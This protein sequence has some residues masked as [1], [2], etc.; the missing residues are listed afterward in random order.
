MSFNFFDIFG[1]HNGVVIIFSGGANPCW[2][3]FLGCHHIEFDFMLGPFLSISEGEILAVE[4]SSGGAGDINFAN[5]VNGIQAEGGVSR[6]CA[7]NF[8]DNS[9]I[10]YLVF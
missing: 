4:W 7:V 9:V 10:I 2:V 1:Q 3:T 8:G 5:T 6:A